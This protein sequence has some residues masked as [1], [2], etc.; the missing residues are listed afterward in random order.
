MKRYVLIGLIILV[1]PLSAMATVI[2][3]S[4]D[5]PTGL[6]MN[7]SGTRTDSGMS[8]VLGET[9]TINYSRYQSYN[10]GSSLV[11]G[12][13]F[14]YFNSGP[15]EYNSMLLTYDRGG[16]GL[17]ADFSL[18]HSLYVRWDP[19]HTGFAGMSNILSVTLTDLSSQAFTSTKIW[20]PPYQNPPLL[21]SQ[22][23]L[24]DFQTNGVNLSNIKSVA[25]FYQGDDSNDSAFYDVVVA[26]PDGIPVPEP[27]PFY[28]LLLSLCLLGGSML[29]SRISRSWTSN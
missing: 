3:D 8:T 15:M 12:E 14:L 11:M 21:E 5:E 13:G 22:F 2:I 18:E 26:G 25:I 29:R 17:A 9:R 28:M 19:D 23:L 20:A 10:T 1:L 4:F 16:S 6:L 24:S 27:A 7:T